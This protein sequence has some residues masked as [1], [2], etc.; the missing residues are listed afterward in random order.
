M[1]ITNIQKNIYTN[2]AHPYFILFYE[3]EI[4]SN[5]QGQLNNFDNLLQPLNKDY[6][7]I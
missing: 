6:P 7:Y 1:A 3:R 2:E 5:K 4:A